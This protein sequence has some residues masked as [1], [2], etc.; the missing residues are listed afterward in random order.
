MKIQFLLSLP[1]LLILFSACGPSVSSTTPEVVTVYS[2]SAAEPW[3]S[4][5]YDCAAT[6]SVLS[7]VDDPSSAEIALRVGEPKVLS[8]SAYQ[9]DKEDILI[10]TQRQSPVQNLT[11]EEARALFAGLGDPSIQVWVYA[12]GED[13]QA[14]FDKFVMEGRSVTSSAMLAAGPQQMSDTVNNQPNT[15]GIVPKHWKMGDSRFVYTIP[16][17]PVLAMTQNEPQGEIRQLI[18]CLQK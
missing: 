10:V 15:V 2:T 11:L 12:S 9:I 17:V 16:D 18:A 1:L 7:R 4:S 6:S 8:S 14:V 3:L 5:L 13:V